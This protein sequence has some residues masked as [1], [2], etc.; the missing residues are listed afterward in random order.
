[1]TNPD[2][3]RETLE[4]LKARDLYRRLVAVG[5]AAGPR[6]DLGGRTVLQFVSN[7]YLG[8]A[9]DPRVREAATRAIEKWGWGAGASRLLA[10]HTDAHEALEADLAAFMGTEAA[11]V[12]PTGYQANLGAV[13]A[14]AGRGDTVVCDRENHASLYDAVRL[15]GAELA[16][17]PHGDASAAASCLAP[18]EPYLAPGEYTRGA[19]RQGALP[20]G[21]PPVYSPGAKYDPHRDASRRTLLATDTVFSMGGDLAPLRQLADACR[22]CGAMLLVDEAHA[23]GVLGPTGAG[24]VEAVH[25]GLRIADCGL[26]D[27]EPGTRNSELGAPSGDAVSPLVP[28]SAF[29]AP[30]CSSL[31]PQS[32]IRNPQWVSV[33]TLSKALGGIGGFV[34]GSRDLVELLV[35]RARP[36]IYTTALPAA[37]C[38]AARA[39]LA[40]VRAEPERRRRVL[41]L[42]ER[43]RGALRG[44]GFDCGAS[45][46]PIVPVIVGEPGPTLA[47]AAALLDRGIFCPAIR[48]PTV[49]PGTSR[50]RV[51][52]T[53]EH[54]EEDVDYLVR[55]LVEA[56]DQ[57]G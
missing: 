36:F 6:I 24:L 34:A 31:N 20:A 11:L 54:T 57:K 25:C 14:L 50:L 52:L 13:T 15:S 8:L 53:S 37:A 7:N 4:D 45:E 44:R 19:L 56:R 40:I 22:A 28:R 17:Y 12:F 18:R 30:R 43:L 49:P 51:S 47:M 21:P 38:E 1:M 2:F 9:G 23:L 10:G 3:I 29:R 39:A 27:G 5:S 42:A 16:R 41:S 55:A 46:T 35:N 33:G 48:P 32:A 26:K